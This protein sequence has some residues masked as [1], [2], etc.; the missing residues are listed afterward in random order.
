MEILEQINLRGT[1]ILVS[2]HDQAIVDR[3]KKRVV[4]L[5]SGRVIRDVYSGTYE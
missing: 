1:T 2:T 4:T 5:E 3:F